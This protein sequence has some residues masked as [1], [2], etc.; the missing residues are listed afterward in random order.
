MQ[1][2]VVDALFSILSWIYLSVYSCLFIPRE[3]DGA[4][5]YP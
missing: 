3:G 1:M 5:K 2:E 4:L